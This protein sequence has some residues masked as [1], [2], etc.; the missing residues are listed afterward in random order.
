[1]VM[2]TMTRALSGGFNPNGPV[3]VLM[4]GGDDD[5]LARERGQEAGVASIEWTPV[6]IQI[7]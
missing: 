4:I 1:M 6:Y 3:V 7:H 5:D 2:R